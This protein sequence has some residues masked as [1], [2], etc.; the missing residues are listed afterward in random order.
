MSPKA[1]EADTSDAVLSHLIKLM[2]PL[3]CA[4]LLSSNSDLRVDL[5]M[6]VACPMTATQNDKMNWWASGVSALQIAGEKFRGHKQALTA[7]AFVTLKEGYQFSLRK[8]ALNPRGPEELALS[9]QLLLCLR[10]EHD[11][12]PWPACHRV[13]PGHLFLLLSSATK[14]KTFS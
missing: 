14:S 3:L 9:Y 7:M 11:M 1:T 6:S 13:D 5:E 8:Q 10:N 12:V 2:E 4:K